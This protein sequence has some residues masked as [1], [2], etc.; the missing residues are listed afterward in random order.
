MDS[1]NFWMIFQKC[2]ILT[3]LFHTCL[4]LFSRSIPVMRLLVARIVTCAPNRVE[5]ASYDTQ[6]LQHNPKCKPVSQP[7]SLLC[8]VCVTQHPDFYH[9][10]CRILLKPAIILQPFRSTLFNP[11]EINRSCS[12]GP[13]SSHIVMHFAFSHSW[14][15]CV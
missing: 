12:F 11:R 6:P 15:I 8:L 5:N 10:T 13:E 4:I 9:T 1:R 7:Y 14:L 3:A 2:R